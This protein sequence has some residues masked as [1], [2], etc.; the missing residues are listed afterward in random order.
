MTTIRSSAVAGTFYP[1]DRH[2][3]IMSI[4]TLLDT[5]KSEEVCPKV[6]IA[7][8]AGYIYSGAVAAKV[9]SRLKNRKHEI[10]KV[11][12]LGPSH[13][14]GFKGIAASSAD[15]FSTPLGEITLSVESI[16]F[17]ASSKI[18]GNIKNMNFAAIEEVKDEQDNS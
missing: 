5:Q 4:D 3:L 8:H 18:S 6:I 10:T 15:K 7:P 12:L 16:K 13:K 9:Y 17:G 1:S 14:V 2:E 11:V